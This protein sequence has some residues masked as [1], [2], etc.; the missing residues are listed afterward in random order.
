MKIKEILQK[1]K[2]LLKN[3]KIEDY[4]TISKE[5]LKYILNVND[6]YLIINME[7]ELENQQE[8]EFIKLINKIIQ[9]TPL[10]YITGKQEFMGIEFEVNENVLIPQPDTEILVEETIK[11]INNMNKENIKILDLCTGSGAIAISI[12][13]IKNMDVVASDISKK[14]LEVAKKNNEKNN[15]KVKFIESDLFDKIKEKYDIIVSNPPYIQTDVIQTLSKQVQNEPI[16]ALDG[17]MDGLK[18]YR[19]IIENAHKIIKN[20]GYLCLEIGYDQKDKVTEILQNYDEYSNIKCIKDL[21]N[22]DRCIICKIE[23]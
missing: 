4:N 19:K 13:K 12:S 6:T 8:R 15:T 22:N 10:Q 21:S 11:I 1:S 7:K 5:L 23:K 20:E 16:I 9:G 14:A 17:G 18:I 3:N 2:Q